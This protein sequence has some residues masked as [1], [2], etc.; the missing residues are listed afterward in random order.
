MP[1][2]E[3]RLMEP[4]KMAESTITNLVAPRF[5]EGKALLI[6]GIGERYD[7]ESVAAIPSQWQR[8]VPY[9]GSVSGQVGNVAYGVCCNGDDAGNFD[10]VCGVEVKDFS[11]VPQDWSKVQIPAGRYAVFAHRGHISD[12]RRTHDAIWSKWLP[13]SGYEAAN[14]PN[15]ERYGDDFDG[16]TGMGTVEIWIPLKD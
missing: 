7:H 11:G 12:I 10:Y 1:E 16:Q 2:A 13:A 6:A 4:I 3:D 9:L 14:A 5:V 15:F 8:F